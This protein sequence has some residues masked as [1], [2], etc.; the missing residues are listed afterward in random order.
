MTC[1]AED[2]RTINDGGAGGELLSE[3][4]GG[5]VGEVKRY[6]TFIMKGLLGAC[7]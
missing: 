7:L 4:R 2:K 5:G 6:C 3:L 1:T